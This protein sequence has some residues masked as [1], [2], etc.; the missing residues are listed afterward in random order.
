LPDVPGLF[1]YAGAPAMP[2]AS[3]V[4]GLAGSIEVNA[5]VDP[6]RGG[7]L[8]RLR[9]G[10]ISD[11]GNPAY[12]YNA[13]GA[14]GFV[15]RL[16]ELRDKL[17]APQSFDAIAGIDTSAGLGQFSSASVSWIEAA[18]QRAT[19]AA[20]YA[21]TL[22][23][24]ASDAL[25]NATGVNL[26]DEMSLLLELENSYQASAKLLA[27]IDEMISGLLASIR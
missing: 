11:P 27:V 4:P 22:V 16:D 2:G 1:T 13:T 18:R 21:T 25:S 20:N 5:N 26:D 19:G 17:G 8:A 23:A 6:A 24:H 14:A 12:V 9:D 3:W 10:G 7:S 15:G